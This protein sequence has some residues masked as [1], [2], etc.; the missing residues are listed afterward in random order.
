MSVEANLNGLNKKEL[1]DLV[2]NLRTENVALKAM[3]EF[4]KQSNDRL[5]RLEREQNRHIQYQRRN[6]VE[7]S[8]IPTAVKQDELEKEV[9][10]IFD[11]AGV[12]VNGHKLDPFQIQAC[13]RIGRKGNTIC[14]FVNRKYAYEGIYNGKNLKD[15]NLFGEDSKVYINPSLCKEYQYLNYIIRKAKGG[16]KIF[17]WRVKHGINLIQLSQEGE[18][19]EVTHKNDLIEHGIIIE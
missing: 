7:I 18:F 9:C 8:G 3:Q 4:M 1:I 17:R 15:K 6:T 12:Q 19:F 5:E 10:R 13:H 16:N 2:K 11:V 14:Q